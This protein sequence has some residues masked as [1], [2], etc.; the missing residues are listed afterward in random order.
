MCHRWLVES[1][2]RY[3]VVGVSANQPDR[4]FREAARFARTFDAVLVCAGVDPASYVVRER[5]D[6]SVDSRPIDPDAPDWNPTV[7]DPDRA[8]R[9]RALAGEEGV[10][11]DFRELAGDVAHA[12]GRL[13]EVLKAEMIIVG[14]RRRSFGATMQEFFSGSV[15]SH[16]AHRQSRPVVVIPLSPRA[17]G[18]RLPWEL[19]A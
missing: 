14:T 7:F 15:A 4:V 13:A 5:P 2:V 11:V 1:S 12:L 17:A 10:Q 8:R 18:E 9:L 16:L 3:C 19:D 6:G